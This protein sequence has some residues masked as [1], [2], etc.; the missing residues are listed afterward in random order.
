MDKID[1]VCFNQFYSHIITLQEQVNQLNLANKKG[2]VFLSIGTCNK[3]Q[4]Y[5]K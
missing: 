2:I 4:T 1:T 5:L 3:S